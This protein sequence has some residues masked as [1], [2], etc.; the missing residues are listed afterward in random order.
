MWACRTHRTC[1]KL[2]Q[3]FS[4]ET[5]RDYLKNTGVQMI[6]IKM[7]VREVG[8]EGLEWIKLAQDRSLGCILDSISIRKFRKWLH[9]C[10]CLNGINY[11]NEI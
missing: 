4:W 5:G 8:C 9:D 3:N 6:D 2:I 11:R 10:Q 1:E 7:N